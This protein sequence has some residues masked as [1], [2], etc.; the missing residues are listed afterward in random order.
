MTRSPLPGKD[1]VV[2]QDQILRFQ[3]SERSIHWSLAVPFV[4]CLITGM[5]LLLFFDLSES[6]ARNIVSLIHRLAGICFVFL[7]MF[8]AV[9]NH[10]DYKIHFYNIGQAWRWTID[11]VKWLALFGTSLVRR[12][13][14]LP[15]QAK[16]NAAE[17]LNFMVVMSTY[18]IFIVTGLFLLLPRTMYLPW[19]IHVAT[20]ILATPLAIGHM[21][22]ALLN[23]ATRAGLSGMLSGFVDRQW[24]MHHYARWYREKFE[25]GEREKKPGD[26]IGRAH[27]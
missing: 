11:D 8:T 26:E 27:V 24:A 7:P 10:G 23:P 5:I 21:Y 2:H 25:A 17:K 14:P 15:D 22:M 9:R 16:F 6:P 18:P 4:F 20:A 3:P 12:N 13:Q 19:I 1:P